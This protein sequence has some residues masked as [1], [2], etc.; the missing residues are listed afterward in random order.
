MKCVKSAISGDYG[1]LGEKTSGDGQSPFFA[2][3]PAPLILDRYGESFCSM[4]HRLGDF[5]S[6]G[7]VTQE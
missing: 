1:Q 6:P 3:D 5:E 2:F 7:S 4:N